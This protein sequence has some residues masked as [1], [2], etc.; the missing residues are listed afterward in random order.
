LSIPALVEFVAPAGLP[1]LHSG[2]SGGIP[3]DDE[4]NPAH[5]TKKKL[6]LK[7]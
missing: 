3:I 6:A 2:E 5:E 4:R 1:S 7:R